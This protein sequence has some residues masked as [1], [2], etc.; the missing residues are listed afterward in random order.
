MD[1]TTLKSDFTILLSNFLCFFLYYN[2]NGNWHG[3]HYSW[4]KL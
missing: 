2:E 3:E 4:Q 1:T